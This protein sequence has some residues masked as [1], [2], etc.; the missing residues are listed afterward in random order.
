MLASWPADTASRPSIDRQSAEM[1]EGWASMVYVHWPVMF[2][3][4][5]VWDVA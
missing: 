1:A 4:Q 5:Y 2:V 3:S